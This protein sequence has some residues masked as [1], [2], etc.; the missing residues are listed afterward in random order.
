V[1]KLARRYSNQ[2]ERFTE[3]ARAWDRLQREEGETSVRND[4]IT[5]TSA[6]PSQRPRLVA[7]RLTEADVAEL[8]AA[9]R[10]GGTHGEL[11]TRFGI[12]TTAVKKLLRE[13]KAR[14]RDLPDG[15]DFLK[16]SPAL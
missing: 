16:Q 13:R 11:A 15:W 9:F 1:V 5:L 4:S 14:R 2:L 3:L 6:G 8:I 12:G 7:S 10:A